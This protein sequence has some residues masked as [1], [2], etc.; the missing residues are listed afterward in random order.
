MFTYY[1]M[2]IV[3]L[4][5]TMVGGWAIVSD[6]INFK[7]GQL[8]SIYYILSWFSFGW[9]YIFATLIKNKSFLIGRFEKIYIG[10]HAKKIKQQNRS[11]L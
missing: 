3:A 7:N 4:F 8:P 11:K 10:L 1:M 2:C 6:F 5:A 9:I